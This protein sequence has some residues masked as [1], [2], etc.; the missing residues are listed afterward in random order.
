MTSSSKYIKYTIIL[1]MFNIKCPLLQKVY[2]I[3][4]LNSNIITDSVVV[5]NFRS[6]LVNIEFL[7]NWYLEV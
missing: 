1:C 6:I 3:I 4:I 5:V 2:F 7:C